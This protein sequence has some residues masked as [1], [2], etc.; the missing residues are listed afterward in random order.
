VWEIPYGALL[1][2]GIGG[3]LA[4]GRCID[5]SGDAWQVTRVIPPAALTG[6][7]AGVAAGLAVLKNTTP[8]QISAADVQ[9]VMQKRGIPIHIEEI[10]HGG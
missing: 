10:T 7:A 8:D 2:R 1:P 6:Q 5:S 9:S 3:L 4:A